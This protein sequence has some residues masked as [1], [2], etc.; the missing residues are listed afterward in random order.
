[1]K[2][3]KRDALMIYSTVISGA[4]KMRRQNQD[5]FFLNGQYRE[6]IR[7]NRLLQRSDCTTTSGF[8]AVADGMGGEKQGEVASWMAVCELQEK[9]YCTVPKLNQYLLERNEGICRYMRD[10]GNITMGTTFVGIHI[11]GNTADMINIGDSRAYLFRDGQL[12]QLSRD[13]TPIQ[14][15][16]DLGL[17]TSER[18]RSHPD[19]HK[20]AQYLGISREEMLI[21][22]YTASVQI[23]N[24]DVYLLCSDGLFD[25]LHEEQISEL[26]VGVDGIEAKVNGLYQAAL[27]A[28]GEDNITVLLVNIIMK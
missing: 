28:G 19:R 8:Y 9:N 18:A 7:D 14:Q 12:K 20:L 25:V 23:E 13:H 24:G 5:N 6:N 15:L 21:E 4:G 16:V 3:G 27:A 17:I 26:L 2:W 11:S 10:H 22:P 1:M